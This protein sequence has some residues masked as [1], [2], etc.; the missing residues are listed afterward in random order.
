VAVSDATASNTIRTTVVG[1][2]LGEKNKACSREWEYVGIALPLGELQFPGNWTHYTG[3][4]YEILDFYGWGKSK[5]P[6]L[7]TQDLS[8]FP[9]A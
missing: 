3:K 9:T 5:V 6:L 8:F 1:L 7:K 4:Q 2:N